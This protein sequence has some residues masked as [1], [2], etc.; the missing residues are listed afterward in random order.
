MT[1]FILFKST[2]SL[3]SGLYWLSNFAPTEFTVTWPTF[4]EKEG[5]DFP[6]FLKGRT[7]TYVTSEHAYQA[8]KAKDLNTA[9]AFEKGGVVAMTAFKAWPIA[10]NGAVKVCGFLTSLLLLLLLLLVA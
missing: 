7:C 10:K 8:T 6:P 4:E 3:E 5:D 9:M 2:S 1:R